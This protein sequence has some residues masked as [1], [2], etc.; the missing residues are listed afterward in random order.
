MS[1]TTQ[2]AASRAR[3]IPGAAALWRCRHG[4][5]RAPGPG[6]AAPPTRASTYI[7][8]RDLAEV[9]AAW[10]IVYERYVDNKLIPENPCRIHT[11][12]QAVG[13]HACV[14]YR[15]APGSTLTLIGDHRN[16]LPLDSVYER[17]L[18]TLRRQ[19]RA[20]VEVGLLAERDR[21][22]RRGARTLF[23]LMRWAIYYVLHNGSTDIVIGVHPRHARF[24]ARC[25][26]FERFADATTYP[27]VNDHPVVP[28]RLPLHEALAASALPR[29][30]TYTLDHPVAPHAFRHRFRFEPDRLRGSSIERFLASG[31][32]APDVAATAPDTTSSWA[33]FW[34][35]CRPAVRPT[36]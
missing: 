34:P 9:H 13:G 19:G 21:G 1:E 10:R 12:P 31:G 6:A 32:E 30:L 33:D 2:H 29:G 23:D 22:A 8:A 4:R 24:Y 16:G 36:A 5:M 7:C 15:A 35:P 28:L 26:G 18:D 25:F 17:E 11:V 27:L 20:L 3:P 14:I